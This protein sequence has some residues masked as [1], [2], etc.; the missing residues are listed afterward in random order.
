VCL[1]WL[2]VQLAHIGSASSSAPMW[3]IV[4]DGTP[5][6]LIDNASLAELRLIVLR[7]ADNLWRQIGVAFRC[8]LWTLR[9]WIARVPAAAFWVVLTAGL[10]DR[11]AFFKLALAM[12]PEALDLGAVT[13]FCAVTCLVAAAFAVWGQLRRRE[14]PPWASCYRADLRRMLHEHCGTP[15]SNGRWDLLAESDAAEEDEFFQAASAVSARS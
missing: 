2:A 1:A 13:S 3:M 12:H 9:A 14:G 6:G 4:R 11:E 7:S 8:L 5:V 10:L 15:T